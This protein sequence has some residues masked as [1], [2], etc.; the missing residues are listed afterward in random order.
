MGIPK[1]FRY[2]SERWP[3][4]SQ[5]LDGS[6]IS[7]FDTL[8]LD[9]NSILHTCTHGNDAD[10]TKRLSEEEVYLKI[11]TYID[12]LFRTIKPKEVFYMAIDGVAP[13]AKMNQQ[14]SR[15]FRTAM[16]AEKA[17]KKAI[18]NGEE[19]PSGEPFDSN[20]ITPGTEFMAKL[21]KNLKYFIH[22]KI[23][24]DSLW[25][26]AN[27]ILSGHEVPG[28]GEHK[29]M[30]HIRILRS[31]KDYN[32]NTRHCIYGLDADLIIL[33][34][35]VHDSHFA[36]LREEVLFGKNH[37][38]KP[39]EQQ[40]FFLLHISIL[41][42]YLEL[43]FAELENELMF[44]YDFERLLDDFILVLFVIG[45][46][47]LPNLPDLHLNKGAFP[48]LLQTFKEALRHMDGYMNE[49]GTI[50]FSRFSIW[51]E[52][53]SKFEKA[54]FE[55]SDIDIEWFNQQLENI[56]LEGARKRVKS[57]KKLLLKRQRQIVGAVKPWLLKTVEEKLSANVSDADITLSPPLAG[58]LV[59]NN[60]DFLKELAFELYLVVVHSQSQD[61]YTFKVDLDSFNLN[62]SEEEH[63]SRLSNLRRSIKIFEQATIVDDEEELEEKMEIY[64]DRFNQWKDA[65][66]KEK[67]GFSYY[68]DEKLKEQTENYVEGLQWVLYYYYQGCPSWSWYYKY[69]YAPRISD[70]IKGI[71]KKISFEK[72]RPFTPFQQLMSVLPKRSKNL[73]PPVYRPLMYD[74]KSPIL[75]FYP[76][77][78]ELDK[79][80]KTADW[81]AVVKISFVDAERLIKVMAPYDEKLNQEEKDRN[82]FGT[83]I[84]FCF[85]PQIDNVYES[86]LKGLFTNIAHNHCIERKYIMRP[87][88]TSDIRFGLPEG[89]KLGT[90]ALAGFPSLKSIPFENKLVYNECT[91]FQ[92]RSKYQTM[93][94]YVKDI[95]QAS[96]MSIS[97]IAQRYMN[98]IIYTNWPYLR[99]SKLVGI[100][101]RDVI[102]ESTEAQDG[103]RSNFITKSSTP[104]DLKW[105][106][107]M[108]SSMKQ[109]YSKKS[110]IILD[111]IRAI[112]K[113]YPVTGLA[114]ELDGSYTKTFSK[115][116][117]YYPLQLFI[118]DVENKDER[119]QETPPLPIEEEYPL[120][121]RV[122]FL[123][124]Y[125]Y[126]GEAIVDGYS[127]PTRL[128]LTI[129]KRSTRM[130]PN[131]GKIRASMDKKAI[132]YIPSYI[133]A[134][135]LNLP[136]L[137]LSKITSKFLIDAEKSLHNV[138]LTVKIQSANVKALG[139]ANKNGTIWEYSTLTIQ[140]LEH[141]RNTF[142]EFFN[143]LSKLQGNMISINSV[144]PNKSPQ[145]ATKILEAVAA[146]VGDLRSQFIMVSLESDSLTKASI[147]AVE[148][149]IQRFVQ[150]EDRTEKRQL[151]KV[152]RE[153]VLDPNRSSAQLRAQRF[154]LG[155]RVMYVQDSGNVPL[156]AKGT[157]VGYTTIGTRL[158][159]QVLFDQEFVAGNTLGGR[160]TTKRG[161][162]L[163]SSFLLNITNR[164]F[165]YH[166]KASIKTVG[167]T[168][169]FKQPKV[170]SDH[171]LTTVQQKMKMEE[172]KKRQA[173][174]MLSMIKKDD[175]K[176]DRPERGHKVS[177]VSNSSAPNS[178]TSNV[179]VA[180]NAVGKNVATNVYNAVLNQV[181]NPGSQQPVLFAMPPQ[182][183]Q[184]A[185]HLQGMLAVPPD[186]M[187]VPP[188]PLMFSVPSHP[189]GTL[190]NVHCSF[191]PSNT[192]TSP[193]PV[194]ISTKMSSG[195]YSGSEKSVSRSSNSFGSDNS[196][197]K[198]GK[199]PN[200]GRRRNNRGASPQRG[201][202][203]FSPSQ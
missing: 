27:V 55:R 160:L 122:I 58:H 198:R 177:D 181:T 10:V 71:N 70:I 118:E 69:H 188:N 106:L 197:I 185:M 13:R 143:S 72:N 164:Q 33:G 110:G 21:T 66:Y 35:S 76:N 129:N 183:S 91:I 24:S 157:V 139:Y 171:T 125:V 146:Y 166:S 189:I 119:Y 28:E 168:G 97:D 176:N 193:K 43:E 128:R 159:I 29:I 112:I 92:Q 108:N 11:F 25:R 173:H 104:D 116:E 26:Q 67:L 14:R 162:G 47:F 68:D 16:D 191:P 94:L 138:G 17:L 60:I 123:G 59:A 73:I 61:T 81:E 136:P 101:S 126:G 75:D 77:D 79:N 111:D 161:I 145:E 22:E 50:N 141:Y 156:F 105:I 114:R 53:L 6:Q 44:E 142:P 56:S 194:S 200:R 48:V 7:E 12:H 86:P 65:Y 132:R 135:K 151:A 165:I 172:L 175:Q 93:L 23:S 178:K 124:D 5:L 149:E 38:S 169:N 49:C 179:Q 144:F 103:V 63:K 109:T 187:M 131:I 19:I 80:G 36:L 113:V 196:K 46:D 3:N 100:Y 150:L 39:L 34:L 130:E 42:E 167:Q 78:V 102:Y 15:R 83:D 37:N 180:L 82:R 170:Q 154:D 9:M 1:F 127:S 89:A 96:N 18:E 134:R 153:A 54:N 184:E 31:Q 32:P 64:D 88:E 20:C 85:N 190:P 195:S 62:A 41:R 74:E 140:L 90:S 51:L 152:P 163:D 84:L 99:E 133:V 120:N 87:L 192:M 98:K 117:E 40:N 57:G 155:D 203:T 158:S 8:Y 2:I 137:F 202:D 115:T 186:G 147:H 174:E 199:N 182:G 52:Y 201:R 107:P 45:N 95:Y 148:T 121:S 30:E 4:I